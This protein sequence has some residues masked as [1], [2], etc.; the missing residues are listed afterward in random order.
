LRVRH[1]SVVNPPYPLYANVVTW[2]EKGRDGNARALRAWKSGEVLSVSVS[3]RKRKTSVNLLHKGPIGRNM[4]TTTDANI[5]SLK[6]WDITS[7]RSLQ[8]FVWVRIRKF[9]LWR[10]LESHQ[11]HSHRATQSRHTATHFLLRARFSP[12]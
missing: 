5:A 6:A 8:V 9:L 11:T 10:A 2:V 12:L 1:V 3:V 4:T 7:F